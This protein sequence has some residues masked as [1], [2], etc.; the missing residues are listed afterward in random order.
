[1]TG[2]LNPATLAAVEPQGRAAD[3]AHMELV[4][5]RLLQV[6]VLLAATVVLIGGVRYMFTHAGESPNYGR[7]QPRSPCCCST[8]RPCCRG[9]RMG[10]RRRFA[11]GHPAA[12][13]DSIAGSSSLQ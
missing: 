6:G 1:M 5:G 3:D 13:G 4:M 12:G 2:D 9:S 8:L 11:A 10:M 7:S